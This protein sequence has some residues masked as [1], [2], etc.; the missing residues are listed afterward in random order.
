MTRDVIKALTDVELEWVGVWAREETRE[1]AAKRKQ[2]TIARIRN[3]DADAGVHI[4]I[5]GP[6]GRPAG[7][8][9]KSKP[10]RGN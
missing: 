8:P 1:R 7:A 3:L 4:K 9:P 5:S 6:R 2:D 10:A